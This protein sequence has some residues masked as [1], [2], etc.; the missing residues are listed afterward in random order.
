ML[1]RSIEDQQKVFFLNTQEDQD[2]ALK[3]RCLGTQNRV[4]AELTFLSRPIAQ[5][6]A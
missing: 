5:S 2:K 6:L 1:S 4:L 3:N